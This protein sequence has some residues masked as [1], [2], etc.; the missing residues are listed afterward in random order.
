MSLEIFRPSDLRNPIDYEEITLTAKDGVR[1]RAYVI[2]Q[3]E[4]EEKADGSE[5]KGKQREVDPSANHEKAFRTHEDEGY[6]NYLK[7]QLEVGAEGSMEDL[8]LDVF[9]L[10]K[11]YAGRRPSRTSKRSSRRSSNATT[12]ATPTQPS[13]NSQLPQT[14]VPTASQA[15]RTSS[16]PAKRSSTSST[17]K[18]PTTP[19]SPHFSQNPGQASQSKPP[20]PVSKPSVHPVTP[21][22][23]VFHGNANDIGGALPLAEWFHRGPTSGCTGRY[24]CH[25]LREASKPTGEGWG[26][27]WEVSE[28]G[29]DGE[30]YVLSDEEEFRA[31]GGMKRLRDSLGVVKCNVVMLS[32]R[33]YGNSEGS[34]C[35]KGFQRDA[36][37]ALDYIIAHPRL[38]HAPIILYGQSLGGAVAIDLAARR[39]E[40]ISALIVENTFTSLRLLVR[41]MLPIF[42][43][44]AP[45]LKAWNSLSCFPPPAKSGKRKDCT[46]KREAPKD[47]SR[48]EKSPGNVVNN[49]GSSKAPDNKESRSWFTK[50]RNIFTR[51]KRAASKAK[52][53]LQSLPHTR[54]TARNRPRR[55]LSVFP[56]EGPNAKV[57]GHGK[58]KKGV[59][60]SVAVLM[61]SGALDQVVPSTHM[62]TLWEAATAP[63]GN[64]ERDDHLARGLNSREVEFEGPSRRGT[65]SS[66]GTSLSE[67]S[68]FDRKDPGT[69]RRSD[70]SDC[71]NARTHR[72]L[73]TFASFPQGDHSD[74]WDNPGYWGIVG[75]FLERCVAQ[76]VSSESTSSGA[77]APTRS[78]RGRAAQGGGAREGTADSGIGM[79]I[80]LDDPRLETLR[81]GERQPRKMQSWDEVAQ[82]RRESW[83]SLGMHRAS[84]P[85]P[86]H[87]VARVG[88]STRGRSRSSSPP[89]PSIMENLVTASAK[90][91]PEEPHHE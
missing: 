85:G 48:P 26:F 52:P 43:P 56:P 49:G 64:E 6:P 16:P 53:E 24:G 20:I 87:G 42:K 28:N 7:D 62:R 14:N 82:R 65:T 69:Q 40:S 54:Q 15:N 70:A 17:Q 21:T 34:P 47:S 59:P 86:L 81:K 30:P 37:A 9:T 91:A 77:D 39:G 18:T 35:M 68:S 61:L 31:C 66:V 1:V 67:T 4:P 88:G 22:V 23:L 63:I 60:P 80:V 13:P 38:G 79:G 27:D 10:P 75:S 36:D 19:S 71:P 2:C 45:F 5:T 74:T 46:V 29:K 57:K 8:G 78:P 76:Y 32:P 12:S 51:K 84:I 72:R 83:E 41:D 90:A 58:K 3:P 50:L 89:S 44:F 33:G 11:Q 25:A 73:A 55:T